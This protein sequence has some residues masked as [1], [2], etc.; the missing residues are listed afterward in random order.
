[1]V[2]VV[3][4][5]V[6]LKLRL[7]TTHPRDFSMVKDADNS[8]YCAKNQSC[9]QAE[10]WPFYHGTNQKWNDYIYAYTQLTHLIFGTI[11]I[12]YHT[13]NQVGE[14]CVGGESIQPGDYTPKI[15]LKKN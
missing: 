5:P 11:I 13:K 1:M 4:P 2:C 7:H 6:G 15:N 14:L 3:S 8:Y 9:V 12:F 10:I